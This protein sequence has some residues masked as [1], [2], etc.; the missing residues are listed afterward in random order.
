MKAVNEILKNKVALAV[1]A[2]ILL[3]VVFYFLFWRK[4]GGGGSASNQV[5]NP[6]SLN[7]P[8]AS[9]PNPLEFYDI[10]ADNVYLAMNDLMTNE[11][12]MF[13]ALEP[14]SATEL[15]QVAK[16]FGRRRTSQSVFGLFDYEIGPDA[17]IF[18]WFNDELSGSELDRMRNIW[19]KTGLWG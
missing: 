13:S 17:T 10:I 5:Y 6:A 8:A 11:E 4:R 15:A 9:L 18:Q 12:A 1:I 2:L 3:L 7:I 19:A 14:L 16:S